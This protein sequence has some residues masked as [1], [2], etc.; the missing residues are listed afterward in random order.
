MPTWN[1]PAARRAHL[2]GDGASERER[3]TDTHRQIERRVYGLRLTVFLFLLTYVCRQFWHCSSVDVVIEGRL[4]LKGK[5]YKGKRYISYTYENR[6]TYTYY[7][8][9]GVYVGTHACVCIVY[10][11]VLGRFDPPYTHEVSLRI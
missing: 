9:H 1:G 10:T 3:E 2:L 7:V 8:C 6:D 5:R 4:G 11:Y